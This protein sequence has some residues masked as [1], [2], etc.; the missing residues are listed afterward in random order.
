MAFV[1][2]T[3]YFGVETED[4]IDC[5]ASNDGASASVAEATGEDGSIVASTVYGANKA[6]SCD[7]AIKAAWTQTAFK[8]GTV[9]EVSAESFVRSQL[10]IGTSGGAAPTVSVSGEQVEADATATCTYSIP[11]FTVPKTH[12]AQVL[13][14]AFTVGGTGC[15]LQSAQYTASATV[16][17]GDKDGTPL[18]HDVSAGRIDAAVTIIQTGT[19]TPTLSAGTGWEITSPLAMTNPNSGY[20]T[21]TATITKYLEKD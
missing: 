14:S 1:T 2:K 3:D 13:F 9:H 21:W 10:V 6:P 17:K 15:H 11:S 7:Y 8:L 12:H 4:V 5:I 19:T 18:S 20:P 16:T